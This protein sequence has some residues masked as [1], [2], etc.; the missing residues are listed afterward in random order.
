MFCALE[1]ISQHLFVYYSV[2]C[3]VTEFV[4]SLSL[5]LSIYIYIY[6]HTYMWYVY[7][8]HTYMCDMY[9]SYMSYIWYVYIIHITHIHI[10]YICMYINAHMHVHVYTICTYIH[11]Y[12]NILYS[13]T[14]QLYIHTYLYI[15]N[16]CMYILN[17][18]INVE[19]FKNWS[20]SGDFWSSESRELRNLKARDANFMHMKE[21]LI[22]R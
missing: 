10:I 21:N 22:F 5:S 20:I 12:D 1:N 17:K 7:I 4:E 2:F 15:L 18:W 13:Y 16:K 9:V 11:V 19:E 3:R 6:I 8:I 14:Y